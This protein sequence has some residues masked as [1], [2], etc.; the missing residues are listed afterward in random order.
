M[1]QAGQGKK[2]I[3]TQTLDDAQGIVGTALSGNT[4]WSLEAYR[5]TGVVIPWLRHNQDD[6]VQL[7]IQFS[8]NRELDTVLDSIHVH[9]VPG[10][11][12]N[13][14]TYWTWAYTW[15]PVNQVIPAIAS[16]TSGTTTVPLLAADQW[17]HQ[18]VTLVS[19]VAAP[20]TDGYSS[21][22]LL[23]ATREATN[24][25]DTYDSSKDEGTAANNLGILYLDAHY[26]SNSN[27][28]YQEF[29]D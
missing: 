4:Q 9:V 20:G 8:H 17:E 21:I 5:D 23:K 13:G 12:V 10:G 1:T 27:G 16:W 26:R 6:F 7:I 25:L 11:T 2:D 19:N 15:I 18:I 22:L 14:D 3:F 24:V 29:T 28:S